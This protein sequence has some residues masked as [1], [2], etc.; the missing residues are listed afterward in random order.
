MVQLIDPFFKIMGAGLVA[1]TAAIILEA[2]RN[3]LNKISLLGALSYT[4]YLL[5]LSFT[6]IVNAVFIACLSASLVAQAFARWFKM[7]VTIFYVPTFFLYVP[8]A[9]IYKTAYYFINNQLDS[10]LFYLTE[11]LLIAGAIALGVFISDSLL[12]ILKSLK[13]KTKGKAS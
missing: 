8:G 3:S 10:T 13:S 9:S 11:T 1:V 4:I 12:E 2:P 5:T 6:S 7:P